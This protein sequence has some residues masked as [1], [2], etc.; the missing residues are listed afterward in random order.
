MKKI[1]S[2]IAICLLLCCG[3]AMAG[4]LKVWEIPASSSGG[5]VYKSHTGVS[6]IAVFDTKGIDLVG[7]WSVG[8]P[9][10][11]YYAYRTLPAVTPYQTG[12]A[13]TSGITLTYRYGVSNR[14]LSEKEWIDLGTS[15]TTLIVSAAMDS[16]QTKHQVWAFTPEQGRYVAI[17]TQAGNTPYYFPGVNVTAR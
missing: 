7:T 5:T 12:N 4:E 10:K 6:L 17:L 3:M 1:I 9:Q 11:V 2:I 8:Y 15:G 16:G 13:N 14:Q